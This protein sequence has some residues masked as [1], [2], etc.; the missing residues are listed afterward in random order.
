MARDK[1]N[2]N[3]YWRQYNDSGQPIDPRNGKPLGED[4]THVPL[5]APEKK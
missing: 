4:K 3:G 5:P 2:I 1:N